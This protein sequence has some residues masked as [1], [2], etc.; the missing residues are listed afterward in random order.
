[1]SGLLLSLV[2]VCAIITALG[3]HHLQIWLERW[4]YERHAQD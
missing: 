4:A 1:M 3:V 2:A